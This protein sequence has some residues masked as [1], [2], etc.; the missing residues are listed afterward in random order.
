MIPHD[1]IVI[2]THMLH[3]IPMLQVTMFPSY[4]F[5]FYCFVWF[6]KLNFI[7]EVPR[8]QLHSKESTITFYLEN[9]APYD[10]TV[11]FINSLVPTS[12]N[13]P[14]QEIKKFIKKNHI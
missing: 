12:S 3:Q 13:P 9:E 14:L 11:L 5:I 10:V 4:Y 6:C 7:W 8:L 1:I 2:L